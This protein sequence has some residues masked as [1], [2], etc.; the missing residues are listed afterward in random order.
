MKMIQPAVFPLPRVQ[1]Y[2]S[3]FLSHFVSSIFFNLSSS[4]H[5]SFSLLPFLCPCLVPPPPPPPSI[6][7]P[8]RLVTP[9]L[10]ALPWSCPQRHAACKINILILTSHLLRGHTSSGGRKEGR[11]EEGLGWDH[12]A[13]YG[14][15]GFPLGCRLLRYHHVPE[16]LGLLDVQ[17]FCSGS[18]VTHMIQTRDVFW[19]EKYYQWIT[20]LCTHTAFL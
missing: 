5:F 12:T 9:L 15:T 17:V 1:C 3:L 18:A 20:K 6:P 10:A 16:C 4:S 13:L 7:P 14:Q 11:K 19:I 2:L 8:I